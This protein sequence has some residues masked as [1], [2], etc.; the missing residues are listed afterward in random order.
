MIRSAGAGLQ[1]VAIAFAF[2]AAWPCVVQAADAAKP[3]QDPSSGVVLNQTVTVGGQDFF[4][5]FSSA[6]RDSPLSERVIV[7][8]REQP[9]ARLGNLV[10]IEFSQKKV[11]QAN[12]P[13]SREHIKRMGNDA[14]SV[15]QEAVVNAEVEQATLVDIDLA[16]EEI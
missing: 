15:V 11:F 16:K 10:W 1:A 9:S 14:A 7:I 3:A 4:R 5:H 2:A 8:V 13:P 6:W 12:L